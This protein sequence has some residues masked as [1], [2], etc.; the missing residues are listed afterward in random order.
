[1]RSS[2]PCEAYIQRCFSS[3][4]AGGWLNR[5]GM[6]RI[7]TI[8]R[9]AARPFDLGL[10]LVCPHAG[11]LECVLSTAQFDFVAGGPQGDDIALHRSGQAFESVVKQIHTPGGPGRVGRLVQHGRAGDKTLG[12]PIGRQQAEHLALKISYRHNWAAIR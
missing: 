12:V 2:A 3:V 8:E 4:S 1:M 7:L 9:V 5:G 11:A 10:T 6:Q